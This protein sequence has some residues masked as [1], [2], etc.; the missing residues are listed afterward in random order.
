MLAMRSLLWPV[1]MVGA[2]ACGGSKTKSCKDVIEHVHK[3]MRGDPTYLDTYIGE[4]TCPNVSAATLSCMGSIK[5]A[6]DLRACGK[7][8]KELERLF[9]E[10]EQE[11]L[12]SD[13]R[14]AGAD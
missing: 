14:V 3:V 9:A 12:A 7:D 5:N 11:K 4:A 8:S 2:T 6:V 13:Q 10:A 1:V